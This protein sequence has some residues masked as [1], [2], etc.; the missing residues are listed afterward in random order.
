MT[1]YMFQ[2]TVAA[3]AQEQLRRLNQEYGPLLAKVAG[4]IE[5][6]RGI[7]KWLLGDTYVERIDFDG[8]FADFAR[9]FSADQEVRQFL[10]SVD[11][12]FT[13]SLKEMAGRAMS[14]LQSLPG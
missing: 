13:E 1:C 9:Q 6:L 7:E 11:A 5:G 3:G 14:C 4:G 12:C 10:R 2:L 8:E